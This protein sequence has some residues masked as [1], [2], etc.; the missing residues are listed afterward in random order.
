M[1]AP[2]STTDPLVDATP[3]RLGA[4]LSLPVDLAT[5]A[6]AILGRRG[7]GKT[8]TAGVI[9]EEFVKLGVPVCVVDTV[10]V[11]WGLRSNSSGDGPGL[12]VVV[13]G[14]SHADVPLEESSGRVIAE[15]IVDRRIERLIHD[16]GKGP[17]PIDPVGQ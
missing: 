4:D 13:F 5:E 10:G 9:V 17:Y 3:I 16:G 12:P 7:K 15:V 11:W 1:T 2:A 8:N 14:G 6:I